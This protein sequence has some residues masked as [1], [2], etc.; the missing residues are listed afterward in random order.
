MKTTLLTLMAAALFAAT[1]SA[2]YVPSQK[3]YGPGSAGG[4]QGMGPRDGTGYGAK[5]NNK[6]K[7][8]GSATC[9]GTG[10]KG[11]RNGGGRQGGGGRGGR[12]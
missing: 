10:P 8:Q 6:G 9:D 4:Y 3:G 7:R 2:Q 5:A 1:A 12:R 11:Q